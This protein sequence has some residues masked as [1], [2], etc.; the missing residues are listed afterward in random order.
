MVLCSGKSKEIKMVVSGKAR[1]KTMIKK[2]KEVPFK[3]DFHQNL[4]CQIKQNILHGVRNRILIFFFL[5]FYHPLEQCA[6]HFNV[7]FD[8]Q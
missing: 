5:T 1:N 6:G 4:L 2:A 7:S 3:H 8:T